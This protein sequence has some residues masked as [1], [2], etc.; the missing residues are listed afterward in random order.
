[1]QSPISHARWFYMVGAVGA[2]GLTQLAAVALG[3]R[4]FEIPVIVAAA[5]VSAIAG[6]LLGAREDQLRQ[7][8]AVDPVTGLFNR[9]FFELSFAREI[10]RARR[11]GHTLALLV[12]D[13]DGLKQINDRLG[14]RMG[15][16]AI[17]KVSTVLHQTCRS[18]DIAARWGGDEFVVLAPDV[19][20]A[21]ARALAQR[22]SRLVHEQP[23]SGARRA[24]VCIGVATVGEASSNQISSEQIFAA[25]DRSLFDAKAL[26]AGA[27]SMAVDGTHA[28]PRRHNSGSLSTPLLP[29]PIRARGRAVGHRG[30][31]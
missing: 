27:V 21:D 9:S 26:G 18:T 11:S 7:L 23:Y 4:P 17:R 25:A 15:D 22:I 13:L 19:S 5:L 24:S 6:Y 28:R 29:Y 8:G 1:M 20:E 10:A 16:E 30:R 12:V 2:F 3:R 14:H 31:S